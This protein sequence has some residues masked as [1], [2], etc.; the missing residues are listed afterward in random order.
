MNIKSV[1]YSGDILQTSKYQ[2]T[3]LANLTC[4]SRGLRTIKAANT[5]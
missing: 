3:D 5:V 2:Q 4:V 1:L